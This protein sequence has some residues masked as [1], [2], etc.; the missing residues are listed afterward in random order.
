MPSPKSLRKTK[1]NSQPRRRTQSSSPLSRRTKSVAQQV[2]EYKM[3]PDKLTEKDTLRFRLNRS[4][5]VSGRLPRLIMSDD[6]GR[7][8]RAN[9]IPKSQRTIQNYYYPKM[10]EEIKSKFYEWITPSYSE[11]VKKQLKKELAVKR[12]RKPIE[13]NKTFESR[14]RRN[15]GN[16]KTKIFDE[17]MKDPDDEATKRIFTYLQCFFDGINMRTYAGTNAYANINAI[18]T[19]D[20]NNNNNNNNRV[21]LPLNGDNYKVVFDFHMNED[22][23]GYPQALFTIVPTANSAEFANIS[24]EDKVNKRLYDGSI[25]SEI[26]GYIADDS[27]FGGLDSYADLRGVLTTAG[28]VEYY[29]QANHGLRNIDVSTRPSG[30]FVHEYS[31]LFEHI[32]LMENDEIEDFKEQI[33]SGLFFGDRKHPLNNDDF[34]SD[35]TIV[36]NMLDMFPKYSE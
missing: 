16:L 13:S 32:H 29:I 14:I 23:E 35:P 19:K 2:A 3:K 15:A 10:P 25:T 6:F 7:S 33:Q 11:K 21:E 5:S 20:F 34:L 26:W 12:I 22:Y 1:K 30:V 36:T 17:L 31:D 9:A 18:E 27:I 4:R 28:I 8:L 24:T